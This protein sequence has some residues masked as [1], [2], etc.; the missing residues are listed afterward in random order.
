MYSHSPLLQSVFH[1]AEI[2]PDKT[3]IVVGNIEVSYSL[4]A[5][6]ARKAA[7]LL[8]GLGLRPSD[9]IILSAHKDIEFIYLYLGAHI[10]G[11]TN[12]IVDAES[13]KERLNYIEDKTNPLWCFGYESSKHRSMQF[14]EIDIEALQPY[15]GVSD[16]LSVDDIAEVLFTTGTT[17]APKGVC[18]SYGNI[19]G[20]ASNINSFIKNEATD[21]EVLG[22]PICHSFGLGR[23]RCNLMMGATIVILGSFANVRLFFKTIER[24]H[25]TGFGVVPAAW[26]YIRKISGTRIGKYASQIKYIEIGS[27]AMP[28]ETKKEM[29][30]LFPNTRICMHYGLT[31]ASRN[32]FQEF[33]DIEHLG[34]IG[35][36]VCENVDVQIFSPEGSVLPDGEKGELCVKG[37]MVLSRYLEEKDNKNAFYDEY[38]RTGDCGYR[39]DEGYIYLLGRE[40]ELINVGGKK[41]SPMEVE[42]AIIA[43]GVGDCV[44]VPMKDPDGIMGE[45]VKCYIL[46]DSTT[47]SFEQIAEQL[48]TKLEHYK[49]PVVYEWIDSIPQTESGK[50]QRVN[51]N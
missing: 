12:V 50:K 7:S 24:Y 35:K 31:E 46:K 19:A 37:N 28:L 45:L 48:S 39:T 49:L 30:N 27:A 3:A 40:K 42:D 21:I 10:L 36:P 14:A 44:C 32:C 33:H 17:G 16:N 20:S 22:L 43:L 26:A 4:L 34:S 47:L 1:H 9:R 2:V 15:S 51:L 29:L 25:A 8:D 38:F 41:V 6:N 5:L 18:L 11:V 13:N 23:I